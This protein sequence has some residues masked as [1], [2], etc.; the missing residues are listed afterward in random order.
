MKKILALLV[1]T[2]SAGALAQE[3]QR[4]LLNSRSKREF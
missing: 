3:G 2:V 4:V 1:L